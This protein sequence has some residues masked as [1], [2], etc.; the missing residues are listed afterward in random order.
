[1]RPSTKQGEKNTNRPKQAHDHATTRTNL[2]AASASVLQGAAE[3]LERRLLLS[4]ATFAAAISSDFLAAHPSVSVVAG[5]LNGDGITDFIAGRSDG[6]SAV[7]LGT[8]TGAFAPGPLLQTRGG[9]LT[10]ADFTGDGRLD[11]ATP[12]GLRVGLGDGSFS[13][14]FVSQA[15]PAN[16]VSLFTGDFNGDGRIDL[17]AVTFTPGTSLNRLHDIGVAV[18]LNAGNGVFQ[19]PFL[20]ASGTL[21]GVN[22][23]FAQF[24]TGDFNGDG[25]LDVVSPLGVQLGNN[26]GFFR[27]PL[28]LP[29][30]AFADTPSVT[31]GDFNG[32]G[33]LDVAGLL[34][35]PSGNQ[36]M[37]MTG[38][39]NGTFSSPH[40]FNF[41]DAGALTT[42]ATFDVNNDG[43]PDLVAGTGVSGAEAQRLGVA[44]N[45]GDGTFATPTFVNIGASPIAL[46]S[47]DVNRDGRPDLISINATVNPNFAMPPTGSLAG[48]STSV[49]FNTT[50]GRLAAKAV[51]TSVA[52]P[53]TFGDS[54]QLSALVTG[55]AGSSTPTG[56]VTFFDGTKQLGSAVLAAGKASL[57]AGQLSLGIHLITAVYS[58]DSKFAVA[59]SAPFKQTVLTIT[60]HSPLLTPGVG[61]VK[62]ASPFIAG[63]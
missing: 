54:V 60:A 36:V 27:S 40:A 1:M 61:I 3:L 20:T 19:S 34:P 35:S 22:P 48:S 62:L 52:N 33:K 23:F 11:L 58:G 46:F 9:L 39:G 7:Y 24:A 50:A 59:T 37:L 2:R 29:I 17:A 45:N 8:N 15:F 56:S 28:P 5:D 26:N 47:G 14:P 10:L 43:F 44:V 25:I 6:T 53:V 21:G 18:F 31:V 63:D 30:T 51:V 49:L 42:L 12:S 4:S 16:T 13:A 57:P 41:G 55:P 32:D 38:N